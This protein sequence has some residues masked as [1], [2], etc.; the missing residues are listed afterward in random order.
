MQNY[1]VW[2]LS[3]LVAYA[4]AAAAVFF[5]TLNFLRRRL[6]EAEAQQRRVAVHIL[7]HAVAGAVLFVGVVAV[8]VLRH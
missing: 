7:A 2:I 8:L 4:V 3:G 5:G 6:G 1:A